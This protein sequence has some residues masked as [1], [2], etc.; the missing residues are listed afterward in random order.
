M[1]NCRLS[2]CVLVNLQTGQF[3]DV[4]AEYYMLVENTELFCDICFLVLVLTLL[5]YFVCIVKLVML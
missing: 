5:V 1:P 2:A 3:A 4:V